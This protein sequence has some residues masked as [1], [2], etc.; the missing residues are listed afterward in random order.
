MEYGQ[1]VKFNGVVG[2]VV[3]NNNNF[4]FHPA[5]KACRYSIS[6]LHQITDDTI[7]PVNLEDKI[8]CIELEFNWGIVIKTHVIGEYQIIEY[9]DKGEIRFHPYINFKSLYAAFTS[10]DTALIGIIAANSLEVNEARYATTCILRILK[11]P[12]W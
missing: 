3:T 6:Q 1:I 12:E 11:K 9:T 2:R 5:A 8:L 10:L 7:E 4:Y